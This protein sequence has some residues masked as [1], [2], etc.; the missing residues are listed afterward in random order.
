MK[1]FLTISLSALFAAP[2]LLSAQSVD[3]SMSKKISL[4]D[5]DVCHINGPTYKI[6]DF[7]YSLE[8]DWKVQLAYT[9][10]LDKMRYAIILHRYDQQMQEVKSLNFQNKGKEFGP[11]A[12]KAVLF[13]GQL[14]L[15]YYTVPDQSIE[16]SMAVIDP[17][18]LEETT[19]KGLYIIAER[20]VGILK[21]NEAIDHNKLILSFS[22]DSSRLLVV[23]CGN[24]DEIFTC[25]VDSKLE[26]ER[27]LTSR[28]RQGVEDIAFFDGI[29]DND[30]NRCVSYVYKV[31]KVAKSGVLFQKAGVKDTYL[32]VKQ[33]QNIESVDKPRFVLSDDGP[34]LYLYATTFLDEVG[35][36]Y[37]LAKIDAGQQKMA[38]A[39]FFRFP[40]EVS[41]WMH[42][43]GYRRSTGDENDFFSAATRL[44]DGTIVISG[45]PLHTTYSPELKVKTYVSYAGPIINAFV[46]GNSVNFAMVYRN[47]ESSEASGFVAVPMEDKL[48]LLYNDGEKNILS[49]EPTGNRKTY[50]PRQLVLAEAAVGSDG[51]LVSKTKI[52][53]KG[54]EGN[55]LLSLAQRSSDR[56][57]LIPV[58][59]ETKNMARFYL[60]TE[61]WA[62][63]DMR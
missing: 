44:K 32:D 42:K 7:F 38:P 26:V 16:L 3:I 14:L 8:I 18:T 39:S 27:P 13:H 54:A 35:C 29:T 25:A 40:S 61:Q 12:P 22:P 58:G 2:F 51:K 57:F 37:A 1:K 45:Y 47:Q 52:E 56:Q 4:K 46:K 59:V 10:K 20:N 11:F 6:G 33:G 53:N 28:V 30:G 9:A 60:L 62:N 50:S 5:L 21:V 49:T 63:V 48:V 43:E 34:S 19:H 24:T 17:V 15:F 31:D 41:A 36:G 55:F 23:Q